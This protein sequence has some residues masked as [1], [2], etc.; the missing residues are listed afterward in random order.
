VAEEPQQASSTESL[1][2]RIE[3]RGEEAIGKIAQDLLENSWVSSA[4]TAALEARGKAAQAQELAMELL[5]LPSAAQIE[6]LTRRVRSVSQRLESV[7]D[8]IGRLED[9]VRAGSSP[10]VARLVAIEQRLTELAA[11]VAE[12]RTP[13][14]QPAPVSRDQERLRV[15]DAAAADVETAMSS[16]FPP[17]HAADPDA[18]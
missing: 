17:P 12:L 7:E 9:G 6:R 18:A 2:S 14:E 3:A 10:I 1:R 4:L 13:P 5:N 16:D 15:E 8:V 11:G